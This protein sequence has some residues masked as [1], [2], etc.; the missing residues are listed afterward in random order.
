MYTIG[1]MEFNEYL[2]TL[3]LEKEVSK[4]EL[5]RRIRKTQP[6]IYHLC[7]GTKPT[8]KPDI[9]SAMAKALDASKFETQK[10]MDYSY[11]RILG[12]YA[13]FLDQSSFGKLIQKRD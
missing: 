9:M 3:L 8:P 13:K 2:K 1:I 4:A 11:R 12:K 6:Y 7:R 5:G 10:L